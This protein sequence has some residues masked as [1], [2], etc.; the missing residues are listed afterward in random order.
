MPEENKKSWA[1]VNDFDKMD[2]ITKD[3]GVNDRLKSDGAMYI[4]ALYWI[5]ET[6]TTVGYGDYA[7]NMSREFIVTMFFQFIGFCFNAI[8]ISTMTDVFGADVSFDDL[9]GNRLGQL[10]LWMKRIEKSYK[11]HFMHPKMGKSIQ[12]TV[13]QAF[14]FDFNIVVEEYSLYQQ[15]T[16]KMQTELIEKLFKSFIKQFHH[17]FHSCEQGFRNE[18]II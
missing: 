9:L 13:S 16:P 5:F 3:D 17:L 15:L 14:H 18:F 11:P 1:Y 12:T 6:F 7:G 8:L 4:F 2:D 10:D